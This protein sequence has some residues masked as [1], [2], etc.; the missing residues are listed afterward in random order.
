MYNQGLT[1]VQAVASVQELT[2]ADSLI[3]EVTNDIMDHVAV[4]RRT[5]KKV[6]KSQ[7]AELIKKVKIFKKGSDKFNKFIDSWS[8]K[9]L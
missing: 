3:N 5:Y 8:K 6:S 1:P 4:I 7:L 2:L 9:V